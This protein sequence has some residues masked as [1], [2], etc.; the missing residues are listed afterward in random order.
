MFLRAYALRVRLA[1]LDPK[2]RAQ[3]KTRSRVYALHWRDWRRSTPNLIPNLL[4]N[5]EVEFDL[6][7]KTCTKPIQCSC[8][9]VHCTAV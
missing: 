3:S 9:H 2:P 8:A 5:I 1:S 6:D 7:S 4:P